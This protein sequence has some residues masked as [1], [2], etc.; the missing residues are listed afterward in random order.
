MTSEE[1]RTFPPA[2]IKEENIMIFNTVYKRSSG[3]G[4]GTGTTVALVELPGG[5]W[6]TSYVSSGTTRYQTV[7]VPGLLADETKQSVALRFFEKDPI[8]TTTS[9]TSYVTLSMVARYDGSATIKDSTGYTTTLY[10]L[11]FMTDLT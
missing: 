4:T 1:R 10:L 2:N 8:A 11:V 5:N 7:S 6:K 9:L 3:G